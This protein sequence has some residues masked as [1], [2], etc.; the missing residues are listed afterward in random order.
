M[1]KLKNFLSLKNIEDTQIYKELKC[2]KNEALI[3]RELCR[4]YVVSISS[5]N[6]FTLLSTIFGNDKYLYLDALEDLKKLIERGF[7]N[8]NSSF[9]KSLENNKTQTLTLALLQSELSLSEYFLEFLE[10]K[11][12]L[13]FEK[14]EAYA[15]YLEYLKD[16]FVRIQLYERLSFIQKSAYNSE[17]KNQIK[18]YEKHIKERLKKSKFY[19][20]LADIFKEYNLEH[21]EQIIF[22]AL[23]KE[24]YAL[25]NESSISRE[26][27]SLLSLISEN[28]LERHKNKKLLQENAPLL[29]LIEYDEYLNA[30]GDI[31]KSFFIIDEILQ[32][33]INFEP[34]QSKKIKIESV[35]K[36]QDIFELI[37]PSTDINDI[38]MPENTKELLENIL[39]QQDKKVLERLHSWGIKSNKN[40]EAKIIFYGPAGTGKTMSAL[41]MAKSMKK[42]VLSFDC[43]KILSKWVGESEQ[44]VRKI[45]DTYKNIVQT[46]KQSPIL[47]LNE[48]DQ[49]L[50]TRVD[51]SSGSDKMHN[52]MQ[53]IFLEQIERFSGV[54]IATTNF[55]ESLDSAFSRRFDYKI[56][57]KKPDF[58][59]RLKIWEKFL[60]KKALFEKDFDI[61]ILS[62]YELSG[63]QILMVVKNTALKVAVSQDGVFKMQDFI[64]SIQK[65]LNSSFDKSKI[66]GF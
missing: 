14:Q 29:N 33:I 31:S 19:N 38:I 27:N 47:L 51:G 44:N 2:A 8:Q 13:N 50:S 60:P 4:N 16:E 21:K 57:F 39:K 53:N 45:F 32:R 66:V 18:L 46:C 25:S 64:E 28:D 61:N 9:F 56:E 15:D 22:L 23:L 36:D 65:E 52:Q 48:A 58:K 43:S 41:A 30:F 26:M 42:S 7:V 49:F 3:L 37:E 12:R 24:E 62:N 40:I 17:I 59:D 10:A 20:V 11:P 6:A 5:I 63:A 1:E 54:I 34:K 55:L 35:L